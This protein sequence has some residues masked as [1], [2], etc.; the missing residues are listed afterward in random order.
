M[1]YCQGTF[2]AVKKVEWGDTVISTWTKH[3][4]I[5]S[6][7]FKGFVMQKKANITSYFPMM[8]CYSIKRR[9][10]PTHCATHAS[11]LP[12]PP[13][14]SCTCPVDMAEKLRIFEKYQF[15]LSFSWTVCNISKLYIQYEAY[16]VAHPN[17]VNQEIWFIL[18]IPLMGFQLSNWAMH[19][20]P[21]PS[22]PESWP[23]KCIDFIKNH[24]FLLLFDVLHT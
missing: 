22:A 16:H 24:L 4:N 21:F 12:P 3:W 17:A 6:Y 15:F 8:Q 2:V 7:H 13:N 9:L 20:M 10:T 18:K 11:L 5:T 1:H 14:Y 19:W 23:P